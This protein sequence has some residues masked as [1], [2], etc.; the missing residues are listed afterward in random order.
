MCFLIFGIPFDVSCFLLFSFPG[1][2]GVRAC[3]GAWVPDNY[4]LTMRNVLILFQFASVSVK[5]S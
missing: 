5:S 3:S 1:S 4:L 2:S